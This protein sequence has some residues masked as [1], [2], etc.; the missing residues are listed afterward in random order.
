MLRAEAILRR[1][2]ALGRTASLRPRLLRP[3]VEVAAAGSETLSLLSAAGFLLFPAGDLIVTA[4]PHSEKVLLDLRIDGAPPVVEALAL[5]HD[6]IY[7]EKLLGA[8]S[9]IQAT[10][11]NGTGE[12][13]YCT[14][15]YPAYEVE[16][17][18]WSEVLVPALEEAGIRTIIRETPMPQDPQELASLLEELRGILLDA[19]RLVQ[20]PAE[21][22]FIPSRNG[23]SR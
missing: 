18:F 4:E 6:L 17:A 9:S 13:V 8:A 14:V 16:E 3:R 20:S 5:H 12:S 1:E 21:F 22:C 11:Q 23:G 7:P 2:L 10:V 15:E 19:A